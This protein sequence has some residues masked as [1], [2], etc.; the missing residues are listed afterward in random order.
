M[1]L[2]LFAVA[3][4]SVQSKK[5]DLSSSNIS[6]Y[7]IPQIT[8]LKFLLF[9][10]SGLNNVFYTLLKLLTNLSLGKLSIHSLNFIIY[11]HVNAMFLDCEK[12]QEYQD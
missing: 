12:K 4:P 1:F 3:P 11:L 6:L 5:C 10:Y 8:Y 2:T 7:A 9:V